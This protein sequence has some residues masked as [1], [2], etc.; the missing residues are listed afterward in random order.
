MTDEL[1]ERTF[2]AFVPVLILLLAL[3][4]SNGIQVYALLAQRS[5]VTHQLDQAVPNIPKA[6]AAHDRLV[7]LLKDLVSTAQ[8]GD[9]NARTV[10]MEATQA[11]IIRQRP[12]SA[13]TNA[14]PANP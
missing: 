4:I 14:A 2:S 11:G 5:Q 10:V 1:P 8:A 7:A 12:A 3:T 13:S 6:Q 9:T